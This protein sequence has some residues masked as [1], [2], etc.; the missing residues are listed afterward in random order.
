MRL[1]RLPSAIKFRPYGH[2]ILL[3]AI[4][5]CMNPAIAVD[6]TLDQITLPKSKNTAE[7]NADI[8]A[9]LALKEEFDTWKHEETTHHNDHSLHT[10]ESFISS[11]QLEQE[12]NVTEANALL[13]NNQFDST[14]LPL[15]L[16][17]LGSNNISASAPEIHQIVGSENPPNSLIQI[18]ATKRQILLLKSSKSSSEPQQSRA[19]PEEKLFSMPVLRSP[20]IKSFDIKPAL[21]H[22]KASANSDKNSDLQ[23]NRVLRDQKR[24]EKVNKSVIDEGRNA[25]KLEETKHFQN[26][27]KENN[28]FLPK[29]I[30]VSE[31]RPIR[32]PLKPSPFED[33]KLHWQRGR[34]F[35]T[36]D[37]SSRNHRFARNHN[38]SSGYVPL[39]QRPP[40]IRPWRDNP[41]VVLT[42][43]RGPAWGTS[44]MLPIGPGGFTDIIFVIPTDTPYKSVTST[45]T[46]S[47]TVT[48][49]RTPGRSLTT[50]YTWL[51]TEAT[52]TSRSSV[53][54]ILYWSST[55]RFSISST[56]D[57]AESLSSVAFLILVLIF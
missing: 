50:S 1:L 32:V 11:T 12:K 54:P 13:E 25:T 36:L 28:V 21:N 57:A 45:S 47:A 8:E 10:F 23:V 29:E 53:S 3:V 39:Y 38:H 55:V 31:K 20:G 26:Q 9:F 40:P 52:V 5:F 4:L 35:R 15:Q 22:V 7:F 24:E 49:T 6:E 51:T 56:S 14:F 44:V 41:D 30:K 17:V 42:V 34:N 27:R 19:V 46:L 33:K 2:C 16:A 18:D 37:S 43:T 48:N